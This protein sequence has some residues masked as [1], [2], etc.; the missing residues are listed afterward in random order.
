MEPAAVPWHERRSSR[1]AA[2]LALVVLTLASLPWTVHPWY[3][4]TNDGSMYIATARS[5]AAGEGY[6]YLGSP[7]LIRPPGFS[8]LLAPLLALRGTDFLALNLHSSL[9]GVLGVVLFHLHLRERLGLVLSW[10]VPVALWCNP[11]YQRLCNQVMSDVPGWTLCVACLLHASR[12]QRA[13]P[14]GREAF[15]G[16][17]VGL[18]SLVRSGNLLLLP[19]LL[20]A[21]W[22][23]GWRERQ[24]S[25]RHRLAGSAALVAGALLALL[26][27][28]LRNRALAPDPPADQTLLYSYS[29]GMWHEDMGDPRSPR[30]PWSEILARFPVQGAKILGTLGSRLDDGA[31]ASVALSWALLL[32]LAVAALRRRAAAELFALLTLLVVAFYFG[33][34]GRLLLPVLALGLAALVELVRAAARLLGRRLGEWLP[35]LGVLLWI[36]FDWHP[37]R[38]WPE[39]ERLHAAYEQLAVQ[40]SARL[41]PANRLGA[42]RGWH[43][44]VFLERPVYSFEQAI[45]RARDPA[46]CEAVIDAHQLDTVLLTPVGLPAPVQRG[47][48]ALAAFL[49]GRYGP[50]EGALLRVR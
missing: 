33:Y 41:T 43:H 28:G 35:A 29:T 2:V 23:A 9:W 14:A 27:W 11:G 19:A 36:G 42:Y 32:A 5:L 49:V 16:L 37:R 18:A 48:R 31:R 44:A 30:V 17:A 22:S 45:E 1:S 13:R 15:L 7:F 39:I 26:P 38:A 10:L 34:A 4:P 24:E 47:E 3:D 21:R 40:V 8:C 46:A 50:P 25:V 12:V 6:R 20:A